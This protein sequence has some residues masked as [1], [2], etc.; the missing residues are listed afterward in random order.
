MHLLK[1]CLQGRSCGKRGFPRRKHVGGI[2][3]VGCFG[4]SRE[5]LRGEN[6]PAHCSLFHPFFRHWPPNVA[7]KL[8]K[9]G[10][11]V[12]FHVI[13]IKKVPLLRRGHSNS[14]PPHF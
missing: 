14:G 8:S 3:R 13:Q 12:D 4:S 7:F 10:G 1:H 6:P 9:R 11:V 2:R 5:K